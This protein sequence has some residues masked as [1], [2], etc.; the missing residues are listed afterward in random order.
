M[1]SYKST[2]CHTFKGRFKAQ[3]KKNDAAAGDKIRDSMFK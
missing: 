3:K 1:H 2:L